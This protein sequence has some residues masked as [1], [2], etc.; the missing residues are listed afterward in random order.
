MSP[1]LV[2]INIDPVTKP[3]VPMIVAFPGDEVIFTSNEGHSTLF[4]PGGDQI[5]D[6]SDSVVFSVESGSSVSRH[7]KTDIF[8]NSDK[9]NPVG[10]RGALFVE[11]A[12]HCVHETGSY[13]AEGDSPPRIIIPPGGP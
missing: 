13:F 7:I 3:H 11:Y 4:F 6:H 5:F 10:P 2:E 8:S 12:V 9:E 1:K